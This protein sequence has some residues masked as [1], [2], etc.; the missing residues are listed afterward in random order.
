MKMFKTIAE[1]FEA[2]RGLNDYYDG[3][4]EQWDQ[5]TRD[6][7]LEKEQ[8]GAYFGRRRPTDDDIMAEM[9]MKLAQRAAFLDE[10]YETDPVANRLHPSDTAGFD[11][12]SGREC[13]IMY[14][15]DAELLSQVEQIEPQTLARLAD[16]PLEQ[17][18]RR[19]DFLGWV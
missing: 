9:R 10:P 13:F 5:H 17:E 3:V 8:P 18:V 11:C 15:D 2:R 1:A 16:D 12:P 4:Q 19:L 14:A 6:M 7:D